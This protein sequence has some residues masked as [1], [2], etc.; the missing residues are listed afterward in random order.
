MKIIKAD[1][2]KIKEIPHGD[3]C[4]GV[5][6]PKNY[7]DKALKKYKKLNIFSLRPEEELVP[8]PDKPYDQPDVRVTNKLLEPQDGPVVIS[9][10]GAPPEVF[11]ALKEQGYTYLDASCPYVRLQEKNSI[12]LLEKGYHLVISSNPSHHGIER[13]SRIAKARGKKLFFAEYPEEVDKID[14]DPSERVAVI[15]QT[16]QSL[17]NFKAVVA[18]LL[19]RFKEVHA[20]NTMCLDSVV[21]YPETEALARQ[22]D[23]V[24]VVGQTE[25]KSVRML[26]ICEKTGTPARRIDSADVIRPQWFKGVEQIGIIGDNATHKSLVEKIEERVREIAEEIS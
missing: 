24:L 2:D 4:I 17:E 16:T 15:A 11:Q 10:R 3:L 8:Y 12:R 19:D 21:R 23:L 22:V 20:V 14:L 1:L 6:R 18:R 25:G 5:E 9:S 26:E 7:F 13:L